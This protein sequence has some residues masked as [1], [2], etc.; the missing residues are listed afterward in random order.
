MKVLLAE[1]DELTRLGLAEVLAAEGYQ[2]T[3]AADGVTALEL[4]QASPHDFVSHPILASGYSD[5]FYQREIGG[6]RQSRRL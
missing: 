4:I 2:V 6:D 5:Y 3:Q 1:D